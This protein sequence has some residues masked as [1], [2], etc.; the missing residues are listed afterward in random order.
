MKRSIKIFIILLSIIS[1]IACTN[2]EQEPK[3]E[4]KVFK[5]DDGCTKPRINK[6]TDD[7]TTLVLFFSATETTK[8]VAEK[9]SE[10]VN[11]DIVEIVPEED[12]TEEDLDYNNE[13]SRS[14]KEQSDEESRPVIKN[15]IDIEQY[16]TIYLG[17]PIWMGKTPKIIFTLL[18]EYDF[19][20]KTVIP[21]CTSGSTSITASAKELKN[22]NNKIKWKTGKRFTSDISNED[23][24]K[25]SN[26]FKK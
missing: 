25:W 1:I 3:E 10:V 20:N 12:Y 5:T 6:T 2:K 24:K 13:K 23:I 22:Y 4:E 14:V 18:D 9:I 16:D 8:S 19:S 15:K 11:S 7:A 17:Y 26:T 21:F